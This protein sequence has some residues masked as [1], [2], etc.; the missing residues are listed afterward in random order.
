MS[1]TYV[2][3]DLLDKRFK[4]IAHQCNCVSSSGSGLYSYIIGKY[5]WADIYQQRQNYST[6]GT[7]LQM[8][9]IIHM[10]SQ[11]YPGGPNNKNDSKQLRL[12]W[13]KKC[14]DEISIL[15][16]DNIAFPCYI[17]CGLARGNWDDYHDAIKMFAQN[18]THIQV[19]IVKKE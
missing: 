17:G 7:I 2:K 5:P 10:F 3:G 1:V 6:P 13:F 16:I 12:Q 11:Y 8:N 18:N 15:P 9:N 19:Y 4:I 14:L